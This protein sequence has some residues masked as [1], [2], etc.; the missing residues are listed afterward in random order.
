MSKTFQICVVFNMYSLLYV[1][2]TLINPLKQIVKESTERL[3]SLIYNT[4][5]W[6]KTW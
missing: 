3:P 5:G 1:N 4:Q 2:Y 6:W